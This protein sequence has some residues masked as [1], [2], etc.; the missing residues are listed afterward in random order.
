MERV[1]KGNPSLYFV[2]DLDETLIHSKK[3][4]LSYQRKIFSLLHRP[5]PEE[6]AEVFY[7]LGPDQVRSRFFSPEEI[8]WIE[9]HGAEIAQS[10]GFQGIR[11]KRF[12]DALLKELK[13]RS[14]PFGLLTNRGSSV[15]PLLKHLR[16]NDLFFPILNYPNNPYPKPDP[17]ALEE[18][19]RRAGVPLSC[20]VFIG[21]STVDERCARDAGV[22]FFGV[23]RKDEGWFSTLSDLLRYLKENLF[24]DTSPSGF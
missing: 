5:F 3:A 15:E 8:A 18:F 13:K 10:L 1:R 19:S 17:R 9:A 7:T 12:A 22:T 20:L 11:K 21:D 2:F 23:G 4:I 14:I 6:E 24:P 16:W